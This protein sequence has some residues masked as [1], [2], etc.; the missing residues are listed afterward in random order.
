MSFGAK[1]TSC[2][3]FQTNEALPVGVTNKRFINAHARRPSPRACAVA[4]TNQK[5]RLTRDVT[6]ALR[7]W[8][9]LHRNRLK[10]KP[11]FKAKVGVPRTFNKVPPESKKIQVN[12]RFELEGQSSRSRGTH[13]SASRSASYMTFQLS[14]PDC[15]S[16]L[17][18]PFA[19]NHI[20]IPKSI[21]QN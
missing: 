13:L 15:A 11:E 10:V 5:L 6:R 12:I 21:H 20:L 17:N 7:L 16:A 14:P 9:W 19:S 1:L 3:S 18:R 8:R 4:S 2:D